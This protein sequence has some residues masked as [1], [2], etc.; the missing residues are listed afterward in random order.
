[1]TNA[2]RWGRCAARIAWQAKDSVINSNAIAHEQQNCCRLIENEYL[3]LKN[4]IMDQSIVLGASAGLLTVVDCRSCS[5]QHHTPPWV[6]EGEALGGFQPL[7]LETKGA[8]RST[9]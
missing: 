6:S 2:W 4:G 3:G 7:V 1:M 5:I 9:C 8:Y